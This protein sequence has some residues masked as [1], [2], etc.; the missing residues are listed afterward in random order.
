[1]AGKN[2][3]IDYLLAHWQLIYVKQKHFISEMLDLI[4]T[5]R[6]GSDTPEENFKN[7]QDSLKTAICVDQK[8]GSKLK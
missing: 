3:F 2:E 1:M 7:L 8:F 6:K 5:G 4:T